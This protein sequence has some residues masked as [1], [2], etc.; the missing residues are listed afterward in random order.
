MEL[1]PYKA[2]TDAFVGNVEAARVSM[3]LAAHAE[4][5]RLHHCI[6]ITSLALAVG[7]EFLVVNKSA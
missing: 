3:P 6:K 5:K 1:G 2:E 4:T 7:F